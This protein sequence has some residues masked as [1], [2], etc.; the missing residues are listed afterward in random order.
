MRIERNVQV[1]RLGSLA[2]VNSNQQPFRIVLARV[3]PRLLRPALGFGPPELGPESRDGPPPRQQSLE[4]P[5]QS[6]RIPLGPVGLRLLAALCRGS[7]GCANPL[8]LLEQ[9][10]VKSL[11]F[12]GGKQTN[13]SYMQH[14]AEV[15]SGSG[16]DTLFEELRRAVIP[17]F[18]RNDALALHV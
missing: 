5:H 8:D 12:L 1:D 4:V 3:H 16:Y 14:F 13:L 9:L 6:P 7:M 2:P 17:S 10:P 11:V 15:E 18:A